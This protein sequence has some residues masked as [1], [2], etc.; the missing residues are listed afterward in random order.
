MTKN[1]IVKILILDDEEDICMVFKD[2]LVEYGYQVD[3]AY[4]GNSGIDLLKTKKYD[5]VI[6][7]LSMP[8]LS[9]LEVARWIKQH[10][11]STGVFLLTGWSIQID[12]MQI[13]EAGVD[14]LISKP[15]KFEEVIEALNNYID[16]KGLR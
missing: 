8:N 12:M 4:D 2:M 7:D 3:F 1:R 14:S 11:P 15:F 13:K 9:G 16:Q 5:V 6:S 10:S